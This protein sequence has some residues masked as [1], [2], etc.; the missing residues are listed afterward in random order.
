MKHKKETELWNQILKLWPTAMQY[1]YTPV[2]PTRQPTGSG[3]EKAS[4]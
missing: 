2:F 3:K 1:E 4:R